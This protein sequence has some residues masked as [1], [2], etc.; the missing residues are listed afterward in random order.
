M[1]SP[2]EVWEERAKLGK[3]TRFL[4]CKTEILEVGVC[5][6]SLPFREEFEQLFGVI[7]GGFITII[8]DSAGYFA[9]A[10]RNGDQPL[11]T[12]EI[13]M[14]FISPV[15]RQ[16]IYAIAKVVKAGRQLV[17]CE[18]KAYTVQTDKLIAVGLASYCRIPAGKGN[19][20][21]VENE[22]V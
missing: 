20:A 16:D 1:S 19:P 22:S 6:V 17:V 15:L 2:F 14:N 13:K 8:A 4:G 9:A 7:H 21:V 3:L 11:A 5:K 18:L 12:A 10:T